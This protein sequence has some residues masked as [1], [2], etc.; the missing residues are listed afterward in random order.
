[1]SRRHI[2]GRALV[3]GS[4]PQ[5]TA[6]DWKFNADFLNSKGSM[7]KQAGLQ[8]AYHNHNMEFTPLAGSSGYEI[9]L[10]RTDPELVEFELDVGWVTAAGHD[11][12]AL[13]RDYPGRYRLMHVRDIRAD[14]S[15]VMP[16]A[17]IQPR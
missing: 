8:L 10:R 5:M 15:P 9:L 11:P 6:D 3:P 14:P 17:R 12:L 4:D 16:R 7:L 13:L 1:M 2:A